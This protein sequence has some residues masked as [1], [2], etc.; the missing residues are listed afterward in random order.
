MHGQPVDFVPV[1]LAYEHFG[2][3]QYLRV[4][5]N[6]QLWHQRLEALRTEVLSVSYEMYLAHEME[7]ETGILA[8]VYRRPAWLAL[9][10]NESAEGIAGCAVLRKGDE[11]FWLSRDGQASCIPP[12][13]QGEDARGG[14][15]YSDLWS[16]GDTPEV[17]ERATAEPEHLLDP[18]PEPMAEQIVRVKS[19]S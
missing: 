10:Q 8:E 18:L 4:E 9:R 12:T 17:I 15:R 7:I 6:W 1:A 11:L 13:M 16:R 2:R 5:R 3:L 19:L 14:S